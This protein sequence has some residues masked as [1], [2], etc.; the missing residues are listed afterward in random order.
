MKKKQ[1]VPGDYSAAVTQLYPRNVGKLVTNNHP[2]KGHKES[3]LVGDFFFCFFFPKKTRFFFVFPRLN[4]SSVMTPLTPFLEVVVFVCF[5]LGRAGARLGSY[6]MI[7]EV[8]E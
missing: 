7:E 5:F 1:R 2:K 4:H 6:K 8:E 3:P